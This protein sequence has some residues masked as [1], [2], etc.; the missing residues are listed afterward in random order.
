MS[1]PCCGTCRF[2]LNL[3]EEKICR[4]NPPQVFFLPP[5]G[6]T[7]PS[8]VSFFP[9]VQEFGWCGEWRSAGESGT[10]T[11]LRPDLTPRDEPAT[12]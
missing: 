12:E 4:R 11:I 6:M 3:G 2:W 8:T 5:A 10:L 9:G 1:A 7:P